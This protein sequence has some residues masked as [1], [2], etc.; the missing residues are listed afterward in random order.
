VASLSASYGFEPYCGSPP[1]PDALLSRWNF[2][3]GLIAGLVLALAA[4]AAV[5]EPKLF[6]KHPVAA[7]RRMSFYGGWAIGALALV[8]PLC[9]LSVSL[10]AARVGQHMILAAAAAP[11]VALGLAPFRRV[12][13]FEAVTAAAT[14]AV[15]LWVWHAPGPYDA[16]FRS[17]AIYWSMHLSTF[18]A[19]LWLWSALF[20]VSGRRIGGA[21]VAVA[22]TS[23][24]MGLLGAILTFANRPLYA[25]HLLT[26][27]AWGLTPLADQ[28]LA[29]VIMW[30]PA[31]F[32]LTAGLVAGLARVLKEPDLRQRAFA[33]SGR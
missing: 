14:F 20:A 6:A 33:G 3:P 12:R 7:W 31:G 22:M 21:A 17:S 24:Q 28:Q 10:L 26:T 19:A 9:A 4:Y 8:S 30:I 27:A 1:G 15:A 18:G 11:L 2:D 29:G 25:P 5:S 23:L 32:V 16:T 13:P